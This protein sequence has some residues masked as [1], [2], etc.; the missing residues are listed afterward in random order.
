MFKN[1]R[2]SRDGGLGSVNQLKHIVVKGVSHPSRSRMAS[3]RARL[4]A[5]RLGL[6]P[7]ETH[8]VVLVEEFLLTNFLEPTQ[9]DLPG[10]DFLTCLDVAHDRLRAFP[11]LGV[12]EYLQSL[13]ASE[14]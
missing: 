12:V 7:L 1:R 8:D 6:R 4:S 14:K 3:T 13:H 11:L 2:L 5:H 9:L 10:E